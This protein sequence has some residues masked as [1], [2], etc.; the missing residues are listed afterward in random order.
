MVLQYTV[1]ILP[2]GE[3]DCVDGMRDL[4]GTFMIHRLGRGL[5]SAGSKACCKEYDLNV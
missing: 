5:L 4:L 2:G 1:V 3:T